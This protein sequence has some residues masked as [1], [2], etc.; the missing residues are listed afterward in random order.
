MSLGETL[1]TVVGKAAT[2]PELKVTATGAAVTR[3]RLATTE[4]R[5]D[6]AGERWADGHTSFYTVWA[7]RSLGE[8]VAASVGIGEPLV[9]QGRL[10]VREREDRGHSYVSADIDAVTVGHDLTRGTAAFRRM[11]KSRQTAPERQPDQAT[12]PTRTEAKP[13]DLEGPEAERPDP[14]QTEPARTGTERPEASPAETSQ[15]ELAPF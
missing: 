6:R 13:P 7:W 9:V 15:L 11:V 12:E 5:Y 1:V 8:N 3:F 10:R 14:E 2:R 4:R